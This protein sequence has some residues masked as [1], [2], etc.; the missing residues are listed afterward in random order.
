MTSPLDATAYPHLLDA[1]FAYAPRSSLLA[2]RAASSTL[3]DRVDA[4]FLQHAVISVSDDGGALS[5]R[6]RAYGRVPSLADHAP[7]RLPLPRPLR[8]DKGKPPSADGTLR[9]AHTLSHP[10]VLDVHTSLVPLA[11]AS[12]RRLPAPFALPP[13]FSKVHTVRVHHPEAGWSQGVYTL[14]PTPGTP[15][16]LVLFPS[17]ATRDSYYWYQDERYRHAL[18][19]SAVRRLVVHVAPGVWGGEALAVLRW[20]GAEEV[21]LLVNGKA[22][23]GTGTEGTAKAGWSDA[24]REIAARICV[25]LSAWKGAEVAARFVVVDMATVRGE[26]VRQPPKSEEERIDE[27]QALLLGGVAPRIPHAPAPELSEKER[28]ILGRITILAKD[29]YAATLTSAQF[30]LETTP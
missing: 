5:L 20:A 1:I 29:E 6:S 26:A 30:E 23:P 17:G 24:A 27:L 3:R 14:S 9:L 8:T 2:L 15:R 19:L 11:I 7:V 16:T 12:R 28:A 10:S 13:A 18:D 21:A 4:E 22:G 25:R